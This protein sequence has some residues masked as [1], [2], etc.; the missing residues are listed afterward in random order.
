MPRSERSLPAR[1][2]ALGVLAAAAVALVSACGGGSTQSSANSAPAGAQSVTTSAAS[3]A[4]SGEK[5]FESA[6]CANCHTLAAAHSTGSVGPN[7]T[8]LKPSVTAVQSQVIHGGG[9]MPA[10]GGT[11]SKAQIQAVAEFVAAAARQGG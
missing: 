2:A 9:I 11:L 1:R 4:V 7:L 3:G 6:G 8:K 10:F 5:V